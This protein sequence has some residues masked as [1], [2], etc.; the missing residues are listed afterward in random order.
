MTAP[1]QA[2]P[3]DHERRR[4]A[5]DPRS[6]FLVQAPAGSG[7]TELLIQRYLV[8]LAQVSAPESVMA[9]TFT[10]KAAGEMRQRVLEALR[11]AQENA[12]SEPHKLETWLLAHAVWERDREL[13]WEL[14]SSPQ[15]MRIQT[16][17]SL[18]SWL[19]GR[20][21]V[22]G[23]LGGAM[24]PSE[25]TEESY[26]AAA[27]ATIRM[28]DSDGPLASDARE[29]LLH[30]ENDAVRLAALISSMLKRRDQ[31]LPRVGLSGDVDE[32][33]PSLEASLEAAVNYELSLAAKRMPNVEPTPQTLAEWKALAER[34]LTKADAQPRKKLPAPWTG[35]TLPAGFAA[36]LARI[37]RLPEP[38]YEEHAW[39]VLAAALRLLRHAVAEL[40][41]Q[42][43]ARGEVDFIEQ[44]L[45]ALRALGGETNPTDL[46]LALGER[47]EHLLIDEMQDTS[48]THMELIR[49]LTAGWSGLNEEPPRTLFLVGD[50]MQSIYLFREAEVANFLDLRHNGLGG[51]TLEPLTLEANFRSSAGIVEWVNT[52]FPGVLPP[53]EDAATGA[54]PYTPAKTTRPSDDARSVRVHPF[55]KGEDREEAEC[56]GGLV[57]EALREAGGT[58]AILARRRADLI[59]VTEELKRRG[60][61]FRAVDIDPLNARPVVLDLLALAR[62][63]LHPM[64]RVSWLAILRAPWCGLTLADLSVLAE[65]APQAAIY[66]LLG[67]RGHLLSADGLRRWRRIAP[68]IDEALDR[69]RRV[70]LRAL[71]EETW[72]AIGGPQFLES[73]RD[74][75]DADAFLA[76]LDDLDEG[77]EAAFAVLDAEVARLYAGADPAAVGLVQVMT[78]HKSKGLEFDTVIVPGL[79]K[80]RRPPETELI[81]LVRL[82]L[83]GAEHVLMAA[84]APTGQREEA[85]SYLANYRSE[86]EKNESRRLLYV[87]ATRAKRR[88]HLLGHIEYNERKGEWKPPHAGSLLHALWDTVQHE[89]AG[90]PVPAPA[91]SA[92]AGAYPGLRRFEAGWQT[93]KP[94][95]ALSWRAEASVEIQR[96]RH[97]YKWVG[98]TLRHAGVVVHDWLVRIAHEGVGLWDETRIAGRAGLMRAQLATLGVPPEELDGALERVQSALAR[99]LASERGRWLLA[100]HEDDRREFALSAVAGGRISNYRVDCTFVDEGG[101]RWIVDFKTSSHEGG[102]LDEFLDEEQRRYREQL[103]RYAH[104]VAPGEPVR[105]GLFFPLL[106]EW[107]EWAAPQSDVPRLAG[108]RPAGTLGP[109]PPGSAPLVRK[110]T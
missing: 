41:L 70:R 61:A 65:G 48:V 21:P 104:I 68:V 100:R 94:E 19:A 80:A 45:A 30:L 6:S 88:L 40:R 2:L 1:S 107:R 10:R 99:T 39:R 26:Q 23:G 57:E 18:C 14:L 15:R 77:G 108:T 60:I 42:F 17:D 33:R 66:T 72:R 110:A 38:R 28:L 93:P 11:S 98:D 102:G 75:A 47:I 87:A 96:E 69:A 76:L 3:S 13:G 54:I 24:E 82:P 86:R 51:I 59:H 103:E 64:D 12:P 25:N 67:A 73:S 5:L 58:V 84:V 4:S 22:L 35:M 109:A 79:G 50:P 9:I 53:I 31:W 91:Q 95:P 56:V 7:K 105:L 27:A 74:A 92:V 29:L 97:S 90:L 85:G 62:A 55:A 32:L 89:F 71:V 49:R 36:A 106:G 44:S 52:V 8:L 16:I 34:L 20:L 46:S 83:H 81:R 43:Q 78:I 63:L 101:E 37:P